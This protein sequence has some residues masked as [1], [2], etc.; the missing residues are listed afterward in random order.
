MGLEILI[1]SKKTHTATASPLDPLLSG[2]V[3]GTVGA[4]ARGFQN[5]KNL[6]FMHRE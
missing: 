5:V 3:G 6:T 2:V 1:P 4:C